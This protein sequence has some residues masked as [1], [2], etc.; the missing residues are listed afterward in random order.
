MVLIIIQTKHSFQYRKKIYHIF[1]QEIKQHNE[2]VSNMLYV[3]ACYVIFY[4]LFI[5]KNR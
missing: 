1:E 2:Y 5:W 3:Q 4:V